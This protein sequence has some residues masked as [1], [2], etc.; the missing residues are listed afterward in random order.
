M[1]NKVNNRERSHMQFAVSTLGLWRVAD[2]RVDSV[3]GNRRKKIGSVYARKSAMITTRLSRLNES[4]VYVEHNATA[5]HRLTVEV[6]LCVKCKCALISRLAHS[7][8]VVSSQVS[9]TVQE[10]F[11]LLLRVRARVHVR[12]RV[13][14]YAYMLVKQQTRRVGEV[15]TPAWGATP[16]HLI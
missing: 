5:R 4:P 8:N 10:E 2:S 13:C 7:L 15:K 9:S 14:F 1:M 3:R 6:R 11:I 12:V 16:V